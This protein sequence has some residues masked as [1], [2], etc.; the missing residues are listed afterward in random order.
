MPRRRMLWTTSAEGAAVPGTGAVD[1]TAII[2]F[3]A[4]TPNPTDEAYHEFSESQG[5]DIHQAEAIAYALAGKYV[6]FLR[7]GKSP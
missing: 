3:F 6:M 1:P 2:D 7:G 4:Q 5:L